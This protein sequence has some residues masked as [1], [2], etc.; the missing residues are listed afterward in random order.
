MKRANMI[1]NYTNSFYFIDNNHFRI[2][3]SFN[4]LIKNYNNCKNK[5]E[6]CDLILSKS[7]EFYPN[8]FIFK[9]D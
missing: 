8:R 1:I 4:N 7:K 5:K 3:N 2:S 9:N 6:P